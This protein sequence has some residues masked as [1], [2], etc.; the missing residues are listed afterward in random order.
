VWFAFLT[1]IA[2]Q[3]EAAVQN[4]LFELAL[5]SAIPCRP[6]VSALPTRGDQLQPHRRVCQQRKPPP[7]CWRSTPDYPAGMCPVKVVDLQ[8]PDAKDE[9]EPVDQHLLG[10]QS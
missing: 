3:A 2:H 8:R 7:L 10:P 1:L 5:S 4:C 9:P 6:V